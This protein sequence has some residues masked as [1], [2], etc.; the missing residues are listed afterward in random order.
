[1]RLVWPAFLLVKMSGRHDSN[2]RLPRPKRG[3]LARLSYA[4]VAMLT[5]A[6]APW[7][8]YAASYRWRKFSNC[9]FTFPDRGCRKNTRSAFCCSNGRQTGQICR[10][11]LPPQTGSLLP[12]SEW[13]RIPVKSAWDSGTIIHIVKRILRWIYATSLPSIHGQPRFT[14]RVS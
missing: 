6:V 1:L 5:R 14:A 11:P 10:A 7:F 13:E 4:P 3:A 8:G 2:M 9:S 12:R